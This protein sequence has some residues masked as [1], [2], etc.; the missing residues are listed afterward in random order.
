MSD[1]KLSVAI[2]IAS[3]SP[4]KGDAMPPPAPIGSQGCA[5][6]SPPPQ[7]AVGLAGCLYVCIN[8]LLFAAWV[9]RT[10][11]RIQHVWF[12]AAWVRRTCLRIQH[13]PS[14][15]RCRRRTLIISFWMHR[16]PK[17]LTTW[18]GSSFIA[19]ARRLR[20]A[21]RFVASFLYV[22]VCQNRGAPSKQLHLRYVRQ[23]S[24]CA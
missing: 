5:R 23:I 2:I 13:V 6:W 11:L 21:K 17:K 14:W 4:I 16:S 19:G 7:S 12:F 24:V 15:R 20:G 1:F 9:R 18:V 22:P 8:F 3:N 10:C